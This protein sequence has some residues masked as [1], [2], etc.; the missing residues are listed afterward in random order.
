MAL[1]K[2]LGFVTDRSCWI[3]NLIKDKCDRALQ[4]RDFTIG[5]CSLSRVNDTARELTIFRTD[6]LE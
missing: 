2:L 4:S 1:G 5:S 3:P 6:N